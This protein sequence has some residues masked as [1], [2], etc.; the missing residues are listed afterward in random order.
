M[1]FRG[2]ALQGVPGGGVEIDPASGTVTPADDRRSTAIACSLPP[3]FTEHFP[4]SAGPWRAETTTDTL[5]LT[6]PNGDTLLLHAK[7]RPGSPSAS[8]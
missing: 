3:A 2:A 6:A 4:P 7:T 5:T 1:G 8:P